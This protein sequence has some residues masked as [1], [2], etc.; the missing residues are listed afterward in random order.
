MY[1]DGD[2]VLFRRFTVSIDIIGHELTHGVTE[3]EAGLDYQ[4][5]PGALN[6][7]FSDVFG[8]LVK[9]YHLGQTAAQ[10]DW[11]IGA[12]LFA[13]GVKGEG[14]RSMKAPGTAYD[15]PRIGKDEQPAHMKDYVETH[16]D[17]GGVHINSGI[18]NRAF[19]LAATAIGGQAWR[20][21]GRIWY[22]TLRDRLRHDS[23]FAAAARATAE[24]S[25]EAAAVRE[26]WQTVGV[27]AATARGRVHADRVQA[28][29]RVRGAQRAARPRKRRASRRRA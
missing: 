10:A 20:K 26:A 21:A 16:E 11:L 8:S 1:G 14:L 12:G 9:Q 25:A 7:S 15:D 22:L 13:R 17:S 28:Q 27:I 4:D 19:Y 5:Q 6:E 18:A 24:D 23:D 3:A 29:R 2:G